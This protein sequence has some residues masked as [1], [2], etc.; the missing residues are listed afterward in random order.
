MSKLAVA[1]PS[2]FVVAHTFFP[3]HTFAPI[4]YP[5]TTFT[6]VSVVVVLVEVLAAVLLVSELDEDDPHP[7]NIKAANT[8][9]PN[10]IFFFHSSSF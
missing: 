2:L 4:T 6:E 9:L 8:A 5:S 3:S 10:K 1:I 7:V